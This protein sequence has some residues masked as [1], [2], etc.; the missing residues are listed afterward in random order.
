[1]KTNLM[2]TMLLLHPVA[3]FVSQFLAAHAMKDL[4]LDLVVTKMNLALVYCRLEQTKCREVEKRELFFHKLVGRRHKS[5]L[6]RT[7]VGDEAFAD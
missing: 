1:M 2:A 4:D 3:F 5:I 7:V 6:V